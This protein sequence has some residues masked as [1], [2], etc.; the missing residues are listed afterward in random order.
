MKIL[1]VEDEE[2]LLNLII[3]YFKKEGY[4]CETASSFRDGYKKI[5]NYDYDCAVIDLNLPGGDGL[6]LIK[7]LRAE[8][9]QTGIVIIS[10]RDTVDDRIQGLDDGADDY[11]TKPF[12]LS[13]LNARIKAVLR[14][15]TNQFSNE[16]KF[17]ELVIN[18]DERKVVAGEEIMQLTKKEYNILL[19]LARN[20]N[21]VVTKDSIAEHLWGD[22]MDDA[23]SYDFIYAHVKNLRKKLSENGCGEFLKTVY[24]IGYK[25]Q[26]Y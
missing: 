17:G 9:T 10:A 16:L 4:T 26:T 20:K 11:L 1:I 14:R 21:R 18:L 22:Y 19:Y 23:V 15:K 3:R 12:N 8:N 24:G 6:K 13:E 25:F 5:N 2:D 7:I